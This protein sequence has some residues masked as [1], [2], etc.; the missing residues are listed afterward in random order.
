M[1]SENTMVGYGESKAEKGNRDTWAA[2]TI[3]ITSFDLLGC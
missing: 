1:M 3:Y 2:F